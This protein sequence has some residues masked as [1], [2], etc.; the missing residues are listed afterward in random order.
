MKT[1]ID[2]IKDNI[3]HRGQMWEL[4]KT[5]QG[6]KYSGSDMG[7]VWALAKPLMYIFIFYF[8]ISIGFK[9]S[10][11]IPGL[12][13]PYFVWLAIGM[14]AFFY[15]RDM[16]LNGAIIF[17]RY[18][19]LVARAKY[20]IA[21]LPASIATS[22]MLIHLGMLGIGI[23]VS[24][25]F[26]NYPSIYWLQIPFYMLC[27]YIFFI[28]W[29]FATGLISVVYKDFYNFLTVINQAVFWLSGILFDIKT[30][31]PKAQTIFLFNPISYVVE[32]YRNAFCREVWFWQEPKALL[33][34]LLMLVIMVAIAVLMYKK[35]RKRIPDLL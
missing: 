20:P 6:K 34:Y 22:N 9:S 12:I 5:H 7:I 2:I 25:I 17:R 28:F 33:C 31:S 14:I 3:A 19:N 10:K 30:L 16:I 24:V 4:A 27:M 13:C 15:Q 1:L 29:G 8:A 26:G 11:D 21:T 35:L 18:A 32:G 23:I